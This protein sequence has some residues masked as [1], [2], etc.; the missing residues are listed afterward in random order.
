MRI[1]AEHKSIQEVFLG[2]YWAWLGRP[3]RSTFHKTA[4]HKAVPYRKEKTVKT[5]AKAAS[6]KPITAIVQLKEG[7]HYEIQ[8]NQ[9]GII[10]HRKYRGDVSG[11]RF[12]KRQS[13]HQAK[14]SAQHKLSV[15]VVKDTVKKS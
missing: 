14:T 7:E 4:R 3:L 13:D 6:K 12:A 2:S 11:Q 15:S 8:C 1:E 9:C 10:G 5:Q